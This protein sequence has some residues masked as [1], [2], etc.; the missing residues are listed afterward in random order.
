MA[1]KVCIYFTSQKIYKYSNEIV[2]LNII[3][4]MY[5]HKDK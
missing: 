4:M 5:F 3:N 2:F 1:L